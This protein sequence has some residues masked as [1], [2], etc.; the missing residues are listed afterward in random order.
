MLLA[1]PT[2]RR[3][4]ARNHADADVDVDGALVD[5]WDA[6]SETREDEQRE[7]DGEVHD[8]P[9]SSLQAALWRCQTEGCTA[10]VCARSA[11]LAGV[12]ER[13]VGKREGVVVSSFLALVS[14][15]AFGWLVRQVRRGSVVRLGRTLAAQEGSRTVAAFARMG[16][17]DGRGC[18]LG[19]R[20][21][22][23]TFEAGLVL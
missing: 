15:L 3:R 1:L 4:A 7:E 23:V 12:G 10:E 2:V 8:Y 22:R 6:E 5:S 9:G 11:E 13:D 18:V 17:F 16:G 20:E 19:G 14:C 21:V